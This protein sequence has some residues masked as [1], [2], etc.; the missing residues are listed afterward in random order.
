MSK[1]R[2]PYRLNRV[3]DSLVTKQEAAALLGIGSRTLQALLVARMIPEPTHAGGPVRLLWHVSEV[4]QLRA[5]LAGW[6]QRKRVGTPRACPAP[7]GLLSIGDLARELGRPRVTLYDWI[8]GGLLPRGTKRKRGHLWYEEKN[9]AE[10]RR[11]YIELLKSWKQKR[12]TRQRPRR[13]TR[14]RRPDA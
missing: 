7:P 14:H 10:L 13:R 9:L 5:G 8:R 12:P 6:R 2:G 3:N 4:E 1:A 11:I